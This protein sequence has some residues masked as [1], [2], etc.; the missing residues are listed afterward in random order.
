MITSSTEGKKKV[1]FRT[2][3]DST[4]KM[5]LKGRLGAY[6]NTVIDDL[7]IDGKGQYFRDLFKKYDEELRNE[8]HQRDVELVAFIEKQAA[9]AEYGKGFL[10]PADKWEKIKRRLY[11]VKS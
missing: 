5:G 11:R 9:H 4:S 2:V 7:K 3:N 8:I 10:M 6:L 1:S